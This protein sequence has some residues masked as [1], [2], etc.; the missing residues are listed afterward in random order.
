MN[1]QERIQKRVKYMY[2]N[3]KQRSTHLLILLVYTFLTVALIG[4]SFL[5]GWDKG[6]II[7]MV[8]GLASSWGIHIIERIPASERIW[9]YFIFTILSCFF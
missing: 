9:I 8:I 1:L 2:E 3:E 4:E 7:L 6:A 5:M